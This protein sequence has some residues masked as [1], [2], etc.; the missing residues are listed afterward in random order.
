MLAL[1]ACLNTAE[2]GSSIAY[3]WGVGPQ[4]STVIY[5]TRFPGSFP[6]AMDDTWEYTPSRG[7]VEFALR[8]AF[9]LNNESRLTGRVG[10]GGSQG[11][12][13]RWA[14]VGIDRMLSSNSGFH[15][16]AGLGLGLGRDRFTDDLGQQLE[17]SNVVLRAQFGGIYRNKTQAYELGIFGAYH[18]PIEHMVDPGNTQ[19]VIKAAGSRYGMLGVE[20]SVF[21]GDFT[22]PKS[23]KKK[24]NN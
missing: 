4:V 9:Y 19:Q 21:F 13:T 8:G 2:A 15:T 10:L 22:P 12:F 17:V 23:K 24:K 16:L 20:A 5:P 7:D 18:A 1:L 11:W 6:N 3:M 14:D